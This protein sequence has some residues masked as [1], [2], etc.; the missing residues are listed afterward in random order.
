[1]L[2]HIVNTYQKVKEREWDRWYWAIDIHDTCLK[3]NY[4]ADTL[5]DE[6]YPLAKEALQ[7]LSSREDIAL[8]LYTSSHPQFID[9]YLEFFRSHGIEFHY[10]NANPEVPSTDVAAFDSKF[11]FNV[12]LDD[13]AGFDP[14][15]DWA[16]I[17]RALDH[18]D[19]M[20]VLFGMH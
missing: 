7:R 2:K 8:I 3:A 15:E 5:P 13:K 4:S 20:G 18:V 14:H 19:D 16:M 10:V 1:M 9:K 12:L 17:M 6:F 11:Y